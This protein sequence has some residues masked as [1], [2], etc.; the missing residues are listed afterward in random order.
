LTAQL[1]VCGS[2][3]HNIVTFSSF[4]VYQSS[5]A[6]L[7]ALVNPAGK[8]STMKAIFARAALAF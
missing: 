2:F 4:Q 7:N 5:N 6:A 3:A 8:R 1:E